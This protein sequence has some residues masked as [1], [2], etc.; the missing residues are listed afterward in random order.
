MKDPHQLS[1][2]PKDLLRQLV[3]GSPLLKC[4]HTW[5]HLSIGALNS[6]LALELAAML[7]D[8]SIDP[9]NSTRTLDLVV[10]L[11]DLLT[12]SCSLWKYPCQPGHFPTR[13]SLA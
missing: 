9:L 11:D 1:Y 3:Q 2:F 10:T 7:D 8:L 6:T 5:D 13:S 12:M 4:Q